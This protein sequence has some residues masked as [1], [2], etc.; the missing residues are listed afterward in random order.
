MI[1]FLKGLSQTQLL[2]LIL[3]ATVI[4]IEIVYTIIRAVKDNKEREERREEALDWLSTN[5]SILDDNLGHNVTK[6]DYFD[7]AVDEKGRIKMQPISEWVP[8]TPYQNGDIVY[9]DGKTYVV[10]GDK[11]VEVQ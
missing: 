6:V 5:D 9:L 10:L 3:L 11:F 2:V 1:E 7:Y 4:I 8:I